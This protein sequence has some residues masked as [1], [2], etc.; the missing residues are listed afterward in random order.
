MQSILLLMHCTSPLL[1]GASLLSGVAHPSA[2]QDAADHQQPP[3]SG[4][5]P[6]CRPAQAGP[7][8]CWRETLGTRRCGTLLWLARGPV[9]SS[10]MCFCIQLRGNL[11]ASGA[12]ANE[13]VHCRCRLLKFPTSSLPPA[14]TGPGPC[15]RRLWLCGAGDRPDNGR[16]GAYRAARAED[17]LERPR[18]LRPP[19]L[20]MLASLQP[21]HLLTVMLLRG[22]LLAARC[23]W[24]S[25][26]LSE[27]RSTST[28][29]WNGR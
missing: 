25:S 5:A 22:W 17:C 1:V 23:R 2:F 29:M 13:F 7:A 14:P 18:G 24:R 4:L 11:S 26:S 16:A 28:S 15:T 20:R 3:V 9:G 12:A 6:L 21:L 19:R 8:T 10:D 27:G